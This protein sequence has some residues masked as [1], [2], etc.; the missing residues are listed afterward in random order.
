M[1]REKVTSATRSRENE[2]HGR[3]A[4]PANCGDD[5]LRRRGVVDG[6][7]A[8]AAGREREERM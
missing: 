8:R 3:R 4:A 7:V 5:D 2:S 6:G 1:K